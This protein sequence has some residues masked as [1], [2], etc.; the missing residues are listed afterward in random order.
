MS[1]T[2]KEQD[3]MDELNENIKSLNEDGLKERL[4]SMN[5][6]ELKSY[7]GQIALNELMNQQ[8]KKED[9]ELAMAKEKVKELSEPYK[10]VTKS[11]KIRIEYAHARVDGLGG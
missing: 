5:R 10:E 7:I 8:T 9:G 11:N 4:D 6:D 2:K 3:A 1:F